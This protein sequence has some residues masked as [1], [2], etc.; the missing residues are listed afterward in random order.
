VHSGEFLLGS[1]GARSHFEYR[2]VG[3]TINSAS[4]IQAL[5]KQLGTRILVT[6]QS[7]PSASEMAAREIGDFL[8]AGKEQPLRVYELR[9]ASQKGSN[10]TPIL[11]NLFADALGEFRLARWSEAERAFARVLAHFPDDGPSRFYRRVA[12]KFSTQPP[13]RWHGVLRI[14]A[15]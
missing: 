8:L 12:A 6:E 13:E 15:K 7:C 14:D 10:D 1:V 5:N 9:A 2:A 11:Q 3:D 4:R